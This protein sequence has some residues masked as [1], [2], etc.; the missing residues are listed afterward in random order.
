MF[1]VLIAAIVHLLIASHSY[2]ASLAAVTEGSLEGQDILSTSF[3]KNCCVHILNAL[4]NPQSFDTIVQKGIFDTFPLKRKNFT[5]SYTAW[6]ESID[7]MRN[8][9]GVGHRY[10]ENIFLLMLESYIY[11]HS[12]SPAFDPV[13]FQSTRKTLKKFK[14]KRATDQAIEIRSALKIYHSLQCLGETLTEEELTNHESIRK[15]AKHFQIKA[16]NTHEHLLKSPRLDVILS[17]DTCYLQSLTHYTKKNFS[18]LQQPQLTASPNAVACDSKVMQSASPPPL[19]TPPPFCK[20]PSP[21]PASSSEVTFDSKAMQSTLQAPLLTK[22]SFYENQPRLPA[23]FNEVTCDSKVMQSTLQALLLIET[24]FCQRMSTFFH[25]ICPSAKSVPQCVT[26]LYNNMTHPQR[27]ALFF[28]MEAS[29]LLH[30]THPFN[31]HLFIQ[32]INCFHAQSATFQVKEKI[33]FLRA[34]LAIT[35]LIDTSTTSTPLYALPQESAQQFLSRL[36]A[37]ENS[38]NNRARISHFLHTSSCPSL[39]RIQ[40][41]C[42]TYPQ[43]TC[44]TASGVH[45][46]ENVAH[47]PV[48]EFFLI[49]IELTSRALPLHQKSPPQPPTQETDDLNTSTPTSAA[50]IY[51]QNKIPVPFNPN[52]APQLEVFSPADISHSPPITQT[53]STSPFCAEWPAY[54][55]DPAAYA[56]SYPLPENY[57]DCYHCNPYQTNAFSYDSTIHFP[58]YPPQTSTHNP[59][60]SLNTSHSN[61]HSLVARSH[62]EHRPHRST[63]YS[64]HPNHHSHKWHSPLPAA[65][66]LHSHIEAPGSHTHNSALFPQY[67]STNTADFYTNHSRPSAGVHTLFSPNISSP[68]HPNPSTS[69]DLSTYDYLVQSGLL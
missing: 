3:K 24:P 37:K 53:D 34:C 22:T 68:P 18:T 65:L 41:I 11:T 31:A 21:L 2:A 49:N 61:Q 44:P 19:L 62:L 59:T 25:R 39:K 1:F 47:T 57:F 8:S 16:K 13:L 38:I 63:P 17:P 12:Q 50:N 36:S 67:T 7:H 23:S 45:L 42:T 5:L 58:L 51:T 15:L 48:V 35:H 6:T 9:A 69:T 26:Y 32:T 46:M 20:R 10:L 54:Q 66:P 14:S 40:H 60:F 29:I 27:G 33:A 64:R 52:L 30:H 56:S 43:H 55:P 28:F 4:N